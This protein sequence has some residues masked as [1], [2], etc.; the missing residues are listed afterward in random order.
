MGTRVKTSE[1]NWNKPRA[2]NRKA[3]K[4]GVRYR[5]FCASL[6]DV[7]EDWQGCIVDHKGNELFDPTEVRSLRM[8]DLRYELFNL[9]DATPHLDWILVTKRPENIERMWPPA[10]TNLSVLAESE[11]GEDYRENV[12]LL[13]SVENQ[14]QADKRISEL[15]KCRD[16]VPVLGLSCEPLLEPID[17]L[18]CSY[19]PLGA[20]R[21][22]K[23]AV[24]RC[25]PQGE[26]LPNPNAGKVV[27]FRRPSIDWV[28]VGGESGPKARPMHPYWARSLRD[29]CKEA[30]I[31]FFFKQWG[32]W[33]PGYKS[34]G[35]MLDSCLSVC[36]V[37]K[38]GRMVDPYEQGTW[39][40]KTRR[41]A[42][43]LLDGVEHNEFPWVQ[44]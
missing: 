44:L 8:Y 34:R 16:Y 39:M 19:Y 14:E 4:E 26:T 21:I 43:R 30:G 18:S 5:V 20:Y 29:Q 38:N 11:H 35:C 24:I 25:M 1:A 15:M 7:F 3:E 10:I 36:R 27:N 2:W 31:P 37:N 9:I 13:T 28:I 6:A 32:E 33:K 23:T 12:W 42:F 41:N 22:S 40:Y 17:L